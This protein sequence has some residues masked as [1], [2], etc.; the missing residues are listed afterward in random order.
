MNVLAW[1]DLDAPGCSHCHW[2]D[3]TFCSAGIIKVPSRYEKVR[4]AANG[5]LKNH[6]EHNRKR[7]ATVFTL[8][9]VGLL[10]NTTEREKKKRASRT[11]PRRVMRKRKP[12][13]KEICVRNSSHNIANCLGTKLMAV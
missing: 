13:F 5:L 10:K 7:A 2:L 3:P 4:S 9:T 8:P 11:R 6:K 12:T 1:I